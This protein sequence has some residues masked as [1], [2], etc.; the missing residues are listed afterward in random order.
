MIELFQLFESGAPLQI[1]NRRNEWT[2]IEQMQISPQPKQIYS[3]LLD[4]G[5]E[6]TASENQPIFQDETDT[7]GKSL[8]ML[9]IGDKIQTRLGIASVSAV[10]R[11]L[12][13]KSVISITLKGVEKGFWM[14]DIAGHNRKYREDYYLV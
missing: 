3:L 1:L 14:N 9:Q 11:Q 5:L 8:K 6:V 12:R 7:L 4:N 10:I 13:K 2:G